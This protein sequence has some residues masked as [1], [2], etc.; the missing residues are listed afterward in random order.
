MNIIFLWAQSLDNSSPDQ[1]YASGRILSQKYVEER[2]RIVSAISNVTLN[3]KPTRAGDYVTIY[4]KDNEFVLSI[5]LPEKDVLNRKAPILCYCQIADES[6]HVF[7]QRMIAH[8]SAFVKKINRTAPSYV[9]KE[10]TIAL[11]MFEKKKRDKI[12]AMWVRIILLLLL[13]ASLLSY[14]VLPAIK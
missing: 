9:E 12:V 6:D 2:K 10:V 5:I 14:I 3:S 11:S 13:L 4:I 7:A 1:I 8:I